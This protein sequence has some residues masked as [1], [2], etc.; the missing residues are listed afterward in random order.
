MQCYRL[1]IHGRRILV[2]YGF[3]HL[4]S[5]AGEHVLD[6]NLW[7]PVGTPDQELASYLLGDTPALVTHDPIYETAW[8]ERCRLV[9]VPAGLITVHLYVL[10]R[11]T[12]SHGID[13]AVT[14][15]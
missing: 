8:R 5:S 2:G 14:S 4:P 3:A 1:D 10:T 11:F 13:K 7:R 15:R 9:T 12:A 6:V